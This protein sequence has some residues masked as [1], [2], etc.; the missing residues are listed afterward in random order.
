M[1]VNSAKNP[2]WANQEHTAIN[3]D[4]DFDHLDEEY[5]PCTVSLDDAY[6]HIKEFLE[7]YLYHYKYPCILGNLYPF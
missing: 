7:S 3:L 4:V 5:V 1:K 2:I 6:D